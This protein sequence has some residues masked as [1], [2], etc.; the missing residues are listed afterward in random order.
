M[1]PNWATMNLLSVSIHLPILDNVLW[2]LVGI[3]LL[4]VLKE[5]EMWCTLS[6]MPPSI[7]HI[8]CHSDFAIPFVKILTPSSLLFPS[9]YTTVSLLLCFRLRCFVI[10]SI[11]QFCTPL[12]PHV[13]FNRNPKCTYYLRLDLMPPPPPCFPRSIQEVSSFSFVTSISWRTLHHSLVG[14]NMHS[15]AVV[16]SPPWL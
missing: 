2:L 3:V 5:I 12:L 15:S 13:P 4:A 1:V 10:N 6:C 14:T 8:M 16:I 9:L 7:I 11:Q